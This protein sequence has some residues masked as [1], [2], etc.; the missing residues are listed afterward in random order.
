[1][2][3]PRDVLAMLR[4]TG[5]ELWIDAAH[6]FQLE[7]ANAVIDGAAAVQLPDEGARG[8]QDD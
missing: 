3:D 4:L 6:D 7:D 8:E 2:I 1:M 5:G